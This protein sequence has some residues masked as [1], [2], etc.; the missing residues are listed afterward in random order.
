M[1]EQLSK[2]VV[3]FTH[4][5]SVVGQIEF[6]CS[7]TFSQKTSCSAGGS[8]RHKSNILSKGE[9]KM[10]LTN[11]SSSQLLSQVFYY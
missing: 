11:L 4:T 6:K 3:L 5:F 1:V 10:K 8:F 9:Q 2:S 7:V